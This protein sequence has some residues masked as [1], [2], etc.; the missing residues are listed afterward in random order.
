VVESWGRASPY[1]LRRDKTVERKLL[2]LMLLA[3]GS[4]IGQISIGINIG[5]PPPPRVVRVLP[6]NPGPEFVWLEG[7]W[8]PVGNHYKWHD[9]Y[10]TRPAYPGAR[11]VVPRHDGERFF[12]GYWEGDRGRRDHDH[13]WDRDHDRDFRDH[14]RH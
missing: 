14:D 11:W 8:Y 9:G 13:H 12:E 7:Y 10:W 1:R 4:V 6:R 5:P 2:A 3:G